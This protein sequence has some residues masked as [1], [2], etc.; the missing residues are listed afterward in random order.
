AEFCAGAT[1]LPVQKIALPEGQNVVA[2]P[3]YLILHL[4]GISGR[5]WIDDQYALGLRD[6]GYTGGLQI[7]DWT[8]EDPGLGSLVAQKRNHAEA[9]KVADHIT[10]LMRANPH[11]H[12]IL[13]GHSGG[14][15]IAVWA[16]EKLPDDIKIDSLLLMASALSPEYDLSKALS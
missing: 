9:Q 10:L 3:D 7:Y 2:R 5:R 6:A 11:L 13:S 1:P 4:P 8:G 15:G 16:L 12:L 14:T